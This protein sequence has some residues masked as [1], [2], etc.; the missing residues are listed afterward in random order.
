MGSRY[1]ARLRFVAAGP[2]VQGSGRSSTPPRSDTRPGS[3]STAR[4][5]L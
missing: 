1:L 5:G 4:T 2:A 3:G